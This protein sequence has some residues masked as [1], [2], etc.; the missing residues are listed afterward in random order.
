MFRCRPVGLDFIDQAPWHFE[1]VVELDASPSRVFDLFADGESWPQWFPGI[2]RVVWT[3][4]DPKGVGTTRTV[5]LTTATVYEYFLVWNR[6]H[7][8]TFRFEGASQPLFRA[9]IEDYRLDDLGGGRTRFTYAV[10]L[11]PTLPVR[12]LSPLTRRMFTGT[13]ASGAAGLRAFLKPR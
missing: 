6:G 1:N 11:D 10:H 9:G 5:T 3:T 7:R 2:K 12:L 13:F 4:P 8:F